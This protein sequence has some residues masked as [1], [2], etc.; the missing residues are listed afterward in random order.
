[1][2]SG[3]ARAAPCE[4]EET[5]SMDAFESPI[6]KPTSPLVT[7]EDS[8]NTS[9]G[10]AL[11]PTAVNGTPL[12]ARPPQPPRCPKAQKWWQGRVEAGAKLTVARPAEAPLVRNSP[13]RPAITRSPMDGR[14]PLPPKPRC[15]HPCHAGSPSSQHEGPCYFSGSSQRSGTWRRNSEGSGSDSFSEETLPATERSQGGTPKSPADARAAR[16]SG[17][18]DRSLMTKGN[19]KLKHRQRN[20]GETGVSLDLYSPVPPDTRRSSVPS[21]LSS[22]EMKLGNS[23]RSPLTPAVSDGSQSQCVTSEVRTP[24]SGR[25]GKGRFPRSPITPDIPRSESINSSFRRRRSS[26][27][28][29]E[30]FIPELGG[31]TQRRA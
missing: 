20:T 3:C 7:P 23:R 16:L 29:S 18:Q 26:A 5:C 9:G 13:T 2:G 21:I 22:F 30:E 25:G 27:A 6:A 17:W 15:R 28:S 31:R 4:R 11:L 10:Q 12:A 19:F 8:L 24:E 14:P 1:M